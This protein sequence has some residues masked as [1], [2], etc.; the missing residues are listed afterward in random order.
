MKTYSNK[1]LALKFK[2]NNEI[3]NFVH[4]NYSS[5]R[6]NI[7]K[8]LYLKTQIVDSIL[9]EA[10]IENKL[11]KYPITLVAV[12]GY[13][14]EEVFP[15][16]DIDI[17]IIYNSKIDKNFKHCIS[18][19]IAKIWDYKLQLSHSV[20]KI[21]ECL[22]ESKSDISSETNML[23]SRYI[24]GNKEIYSSFK[25][26]I[27]Q[28]SASSKKNFVNKKIIE[29]EI[30]HNKFNATSYMLEPNIKECIGGM[31]D[32]N[33]IFWVSKKVYGISDFHGHY[34][35]K[36]ISKKE[37]NQVKSSR[38]FLFNVR[39]LLHYLNKKPL[40][41]LYFENQI[42]LAKFLN[43]RGN[44]NQPVER[45]MKN[46]Y[47][48]ISVVKH[49][50][51]IILNYINFN[52]K[53]LRGRFIK[54]NNYF[55]SKDN[56][57]FINNDE[58]FLKNPSLLLEIFYVM[59]NRNLQEIEPRTLRLINDS[60]YLIDSKFRNSK[61]NQIAFMNI[62]K[63]D[64]N[65]TKILRKMSES[66][67]LGSYW[68]A[69]KKSIGQMQFD[70]FH[71]YTVDEHTLSVLS[72]L[73]FMG[74]KECN[75]KYKFIYEVYKNIKD[76]EVLYL[77]SLFHD[78]GKGSNKD[79]SKVGKDLIYKFA[80]KHGLSEHQSNTASW[81]VENHLLM[82]LTVQ[83]K[84][85][86]DPIEVIKF[87]TNVKTQERLDY[88][89]LLTIA[90]IRGTNPKLYTDW[91]D[92]LL[93]EFYLLT[94]KYIAT[95]SILDSSKDAYIKNIKSSVL[96][97]LNTLNNKKF[98]EDMWSQLPI[99]YYQK[100]NDEDL[101]WHSECL[102]KK[103][104]NKD[105]MQIRESP[106]RGCTQL[107][108]YQKTRKNLL[109]KITSVFE[110][111]NIQITEAN[112]VTLSNNSSIDTYLL[113]DSSG[114]QIKNKY[115]LNDLKNNIE[116]VLIDPEKVKI[117]K[118]TKKASYTKDFTSVLDVEV[119]SKNNSVTIEVNALDSPG[120]LSS[121]CE[122]MD[123]SNLMIKDAKVSTLGEQ[124]NDIF[125]VESINFDNFDNFSKKIKNKLKQKLSDLY[126]SQM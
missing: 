10:W 99:D 47:K 98:L 62:L 7:E 22:K 125:F 96:K 61:T 6:N 46:L 52:L 69:F 37:F 81:L 80:I 117:S 21:N 90:D 38:N 120:L 111:L 115:M 77:S 97:K 4:K 74:T 41:R 33:N 43:Y 40:E 31:R 76:K 109:R 100:H 91:K 87:A 57:I 2:S 36:I 29:Q 95:N 42:S 11:D 39:Y 12:G 55:Y 116:Q 19:F 93:K 9:I 32:L 68:P 85:I 60:L 104:T 54:I 23:E 1:E 119:Y 79:H 5:N 124:V 44:G 92:H 71:I 65:V 8:L 51:N 58:S 86:N 106:Y 15:Y 30:R 13:G 72:N 78:I 83:K 84:D 88:L 126:N 45:F 28:G 118:K 50:N 75:K 24:F 16:S 108:I 110:K 53:A 48:N 105:F 18:S 66:G 121:I 73:R 82:S 67:V 113:L 20:R 112:I 123:D 122:V 70:L 64:F 102:M 3:N 94:S 114:K 26:K 34:D 27:T 35:N 59:Q 107:M 103:G 89:Y 17:L 56:M 63:N 25:N 49:T 14:R 101:E